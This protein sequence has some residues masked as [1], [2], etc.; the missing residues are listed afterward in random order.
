MDMQATS[1]KR[2]ASSLLNANARQSTTSVVS[3]SPPHARQAA[4]LTYGE[5]QPDTPMTTTIVLNGLLMQT[6]T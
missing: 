5:Q 2:P 1:W 4:V 3:I 6:A